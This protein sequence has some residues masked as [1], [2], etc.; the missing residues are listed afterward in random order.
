MTGEYIPFLKTP[1]S[2]YILNP[3]PPR[4]SRIGKL[5]DLVRLELTTM[6]FAGISSLSFSNVYPG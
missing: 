6:P 1:Y 3:P 5:T 4:P 2:L